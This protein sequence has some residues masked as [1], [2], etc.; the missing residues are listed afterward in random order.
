MPRHHAISVS[1]YSDAEDA[2]AAGVVS[3]V[4]RITELLA[5]K[6]QFDPEQAHR[7]IG[8]DR[9]KFEK[10]P[11]GMVLVQ[12]REPVGPK[13]AALLDFLWEQGGENVKFK[14]S[15]EKVELEV[16]RRFSLYMPKTEKETSVTTMGCGWH[17]NCVDGCLHACICPLTRP[18]RTWL[19]WHTK[20]PRSRVKRCYGDTQSVVEIGG[21][22][23]NIIHVR[24]DDTEFEARVG[25]YKVMWE[26]ASNEWC[27]NAVADDKEWADTLISA[28]PA[29]SLLPDD[30]L[31]MIA[32]HGVADKCIASNKAK[33]KAH[34]ARITAAAHAAAAA[35]SAKTFIRRY[36]LVKR[37]LVGE[38]RS[39]QRLIHKLYLKPSRNSTVDTRVR[40]RASLD[41]RVRAATEMDELVTASLVTARTAQQKAEAAYIVATIIAK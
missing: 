41:A 38:H 34:N 6:F 12:Q 26:E 2:V 17:D 19:H 35:Q 33:L 9:L 28:S 15:R 20:L 14:Y 10:K 1:V 13:V 22:V 36:S 23:P 37:E 11:T 32:N 5:T 18:H 39:L 30:C 7:F 29:L 8:A 16:C 3:T 21:G 40:D 31:E 25:I 4:K 24:P 27:S